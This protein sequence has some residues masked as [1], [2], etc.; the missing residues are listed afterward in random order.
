MQEQQAA[1][2]SKEAKRAA[3]DRIALEAFRAAALQ[4]CDSLYFPPSPRIDDY[5]QFPPPPPAVVDDTETK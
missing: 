2:R 1:G 5:V 4:V 3:E